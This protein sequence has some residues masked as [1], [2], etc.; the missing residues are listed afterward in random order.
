MVSSAEGLLDIQTSSL[1]MGLI[2]I[3]SSHVIAC[4]WRESAYLICLVIH[5]SVVI[6]SESS[7][8][9][10]GYQVSKLFLY[11]YCCLS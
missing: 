5:C 9:P 2:F 8:A 3:V 10:L 6:H 4:K 7:N 11:S 1:V